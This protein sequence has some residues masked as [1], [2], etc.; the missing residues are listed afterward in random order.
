MPEV[1]ELTKDN[2]LEVARRVADVVASGGIAVFPTDT[3]YGIGCDATNA[4]AVDKIYKI[5]NR[6]GNKPLQIIVSDIEMLLRYAE[7][8]EEQEIFL[9]KYIPG[10]FTFVLKQKAYLPASPTLGKIAVRLPELPFVRMIAEYLGNPI[11]A[12]SANISGYPAPYS[13]SDI[14]DRIR[15]SSDVCVD[16]GKTRYKEASTVVDLVSKKILRK[17]AGYERI[18]SKH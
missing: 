1:L 13:F 6:P 3:V 8:T 16:G 12:T 4:D 15:G 10:P 17:G 11:A 9:K 5:K 7:L 14:T 2:A 18:A